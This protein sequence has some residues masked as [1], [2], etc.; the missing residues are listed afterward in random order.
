MTALPL[1]PTREEF[2]DLAGQGNL[3]PVYTEFVADCETPIGVFEKID[4]GVR[5]F[6][7]E[8]AESNDHVGRYSILGSD[9]RIYFEASGK[10]I[11]IEEG[12]QTREFETEE[13]PLIELQKLMAQFKA[14][15]LPGLP[16]FT[17]GAV[18]YIGYDSVRFFEPTVGEP[19]PDQLK[20]PDMVF[21]ITDT[22][23][24]FDHR[25]RRLKIF[26]NALIGPE[27]ADAA[28]DEAEG[29]IRAI[30]RKLE[31]PTQSRLMNAAQAAIS[32]SP[33]SNTAKDE[34]FDM[35]LR[36]KEYIGAGDIFQMVPS[37]RF[38]ARFEGNPLSL[39]RALRFINPSPYM[40]CVRLGEKFALVGSSPEVHVRLVKG[41]IEIRPIAGTRKR[42][43]T[44]AEDQ[45]L[46]EELLA[47]PKE[48]AEHLMLVD[49]ARNDVGRISEF[50]SV[51]LTDF[52]T[53]ERYSH[54]MHI[55]SNV[56]GRLSE[57]QT[58][59]DVMRATFP[60]GTVSGAPKVRAMQLIYE[61]E[62]SKRGVYAGA[63]GYFGFDGQLDSCIALRTVLLKDG[64]AFVQAGG[65]VVADSEPEAEY[66]ESVNK[67]MAVF[68]AIERAEELI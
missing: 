21:V 36:A 49:L 24:V 58:A 37:Q 10:K 19:P 13:D 7:F 54:V 8:S 32:L 42:G 68:R 1:I 31:T 27:G 39:Y 40:F 30:V 47:D 38:E 18:G 5:S 14:V 61:F 26:A 29:K 50:G 12:N 6:L 67:A 41:Q 22:F 16:P 65:G 34:Y 55:V 56:I 59:Y 63:V 15:T 2:R 46:A 60:A 45:E 53:I 11:L 48:R 9:P 66:Q 28:Y 64:V 44:I 4:N 62:K 43:K 57:G 17:G 25:F 3:I 23:L 52:M 20:V 35:V 33:R 51:R